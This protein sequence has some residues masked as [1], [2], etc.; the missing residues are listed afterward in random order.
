MNGD[1]KRPEHTP[2]I[3]ERLAPGDHRI[4]VPLATARE[5][6]LKN[7]PDLTLKTIRR[8]GS[9][10]NNSGFLI[11]G[12]HVFRFAKYEQASRSLDI[13]TAVLPEI[14]KVVELPIPRIECTGIQANGLRFAGYGLIKGIGLEKKHLLERGQLKVALVQKLA[15][16]LEQFHSVDTETAKRGGVETRD[17]HLFYKETLR[18]AQKFFYPFVREKLPQDARKIESYVEAIFRQ[19]FKDQRNFDFQPALCHND[20]SGEHIMYSLKED[21]ISGII[22]FG[23]M[24]VTDPDFDTWRLHRDYGEEFTRDLLKFNPHSNPDLLLKK[25]DFYRR[26]QTVRN[27]VRRLM[28]KDDISPIMGS[29]LRFFKQDTGG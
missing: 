26:A 7:F 5:S 3:T 20:L 22:D 19:Y 1:L 11:N 17:P 6:I 4:E 25:L 24:K 13:E 23:S 9:G 16:F 18:D 2:D 8:F 21:D 15:K 10:M 27:M 14:S 29:F 28:V 12:T